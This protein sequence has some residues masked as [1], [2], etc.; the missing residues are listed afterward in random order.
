LVGDIFLIMAA[1]TNPISILLSINF[2]AQTDGISNCKLI[3]WLEN[4]FFNPYTN[5]MVLV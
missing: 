4:V 3:S 2:W 1:G 5:G